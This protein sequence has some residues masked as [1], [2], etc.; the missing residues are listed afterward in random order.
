MFKDTIDA[1]AE[2]IQVIS[3]LD[4]LAGAVRQ[5][6]MNGISVNY[7]GAQD[8]ALIRRLAEVGVDYILT[9]DLDLCLKVLAEY[10]VTPPR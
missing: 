5:L 10:G 2:F 1:R 4:G 3:G 7:F 8:A 6:H 9:D